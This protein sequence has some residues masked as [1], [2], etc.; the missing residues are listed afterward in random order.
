[1][2]LFVLIIV[3]LIVAQTWLDW[4]DT[5]R[6]W[7]VPDWAKGTALAGVLT[8]SLTAAASFASAWIQDPAA[9]RAIDFGS[10]LFWPEFAFIFCM[11]GV[12]V[13][14]VRKQR[15]RLMLLIVAVALSVFSI[16]LALS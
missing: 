4:R 2:A 12:I 8:V 15:L 13:F 5:S 9:E 6:N 16:G 11:L 3:A 7:K 1:M 14:T 10:H